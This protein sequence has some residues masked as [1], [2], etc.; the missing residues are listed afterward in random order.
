MAPLKLFG[1]AED[2]RAAI[3]AAP[4]IA[5]AGTGLGPVDG[6]LC[7]DKS[8]LLNSSLCFLLL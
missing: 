8:I 2:D 4:A 1:L 6:G 3:P 5:T 7:N